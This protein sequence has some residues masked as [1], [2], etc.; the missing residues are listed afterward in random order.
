MRTFAPQI[1]RWRAAATAYGQGL[2]PDLILQ[3]I[4]SESGGTP[5]ICS[6]AAACGLMQCKRA[7]VDAFNR[8]HPSS[9]VD[10][11]VMNGTRL[12]DAAQQIRVGSWLYR[13]HLERAHEL[14]P[15]A[16]PWPTA[17]LSTWQIHAADLMYSHGRG[18]FEQLRRAALAA[19]YPDDIDGWASYQRAHAPGWTSENPFR[20]AARAAAS[21]LDAPG[22]TRMPAR[23]K[24][25]ADTGGSL[26]AIL[27]AAA[28][29]W[30]AFR[31]TR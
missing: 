31:R 25:T 22:A 16:A 8:T 15:H 28:F 12:D 3:T 11:R 13:R 27:A 6:R 20:H 5:G 2:P 17:P 24:T 9:P 10:W 7:V 30:F 18:A 29:A 26:A 4:A 21:I 19:G 23:A 14:A 1:E